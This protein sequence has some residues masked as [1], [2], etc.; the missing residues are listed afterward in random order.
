[1]RRPRVGCPTGWL[2]LTI[3]YY[4]ER[5]PAMSP[6]SG[7]WPSLSVGTKPFLLFGPGLH[8]NGRIRPPKWALTPIRRLRVFCMIGNHNV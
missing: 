5:E 7:T 3:G 2:L 8:R 6:N 1:M 4:S